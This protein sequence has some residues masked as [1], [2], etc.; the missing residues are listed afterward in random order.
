MQVTHLLAVF[1]QILSQI[2]GH[3]LGERGDQH[4]LVNRHTLADFR[5]QVINLRGY[6]SHFDDRIQQTGR[7]HDLIDHIVT[8][9]LQLVFARRGR[10]INTLRRQGFEFLKAHRAVIQRRRQAE[11][12]FHQRFFTRAVA[13]VHTADLRNGDVRFI[14]NQQA[15]SRQI[16]KQ[17]RRRLARPAAR[18]IT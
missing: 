8:G 9:F 4:T 1:F 13:F 18:Q 6:R 10:D 12:V 5:Q 15:V 7:T 2:L 16:I 11:T 3:T 17:R 14:D